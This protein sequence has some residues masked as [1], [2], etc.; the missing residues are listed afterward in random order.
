MGSKPEKKYRTTPNRGGLIRGNT[1]R[2]QVLMVPITSSQ[3]LRS[4]KRTSHLKK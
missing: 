4:M 2:F 3:S 1:T